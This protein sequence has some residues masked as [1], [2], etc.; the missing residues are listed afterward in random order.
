M[1]S[2]D[3]RSLLPAYMAYGA[4][5]AYLLLSV[6]FLA[7]TLSM[8]SYG[9]LLTGM[10][11]MNV[12][13]LVCSYGLDL[14]GARQLA[15]DRHSNANAILATNISAR[16][17]ALLL[18]VGGVLAWTCVFQHPLLQPMMVAA[19][20]SAGVLAALNA[21]WF[22]QGQGQFFT[23]AVLEA[24]TYV[25]SL[26]GFVLIL[27]DESAPQ[28]AMWVLACAS[29][30]TT[31]VGLWL[32]SRQGHFKLKLS[33]RNGVLLWRDAWRLSIVRC[34]TPFTSAVGTLILSMMF[35]AAQI[36]PFAVAERMSTAVLSLFEPARQV[37]M[38][39]AA[40]QI[41][42]RV[43]FSTE[44][45]AMSKVIRMQA[46]FGGAMALAVWLVQPW[47]LPWWLGADYGL[48]QHF[49]AIF[50]FAFPCIAYSEALKNYYFLP[51]QQDEL[52]AV[53]CVFGS[54]MSLAMMTLAAGYRL[55]LTDSIVG[56]NVA[57]ILLAYL[58]VRLMRKTAKGI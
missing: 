2:L 44:Q 5:I 38:R 53:V 35:P 45:L 13:S 4:R 37:F 16:L 12:V 47:I 50:A 51:Y 9:E 11:L 52:V 42:E 34:A 40:L 58:L 18:F 26:L 55:E 21:G 43:V 36:A 10:A 48:V 25:L 23:S 57:E 56:R 6:P 32:A 20:L 1:S 49:L 14:H 15:L 29:G 22:F 17:M 27:S 46:I 24:S 19:A 41:N 54:L 7:H 28:H 31:M 33:W 39:R 8:T 30:I 3:A